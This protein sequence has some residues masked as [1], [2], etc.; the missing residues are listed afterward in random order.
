MT[1]SV[2]ARRHHYEFAHRT[3]PE[4]VR[5]GRFDLVEMAEHDVL[6]PA[7]LGAW[8]ALGDALPPQE[9]VDAQGL[10]VWAVDLAGG[11]ALLVRFP[12]VQRLPEALLAAVLP[13]ADG[14]PPRYLTLEFAGT[15]DGQVQTMIGEWDGEA[16]R[17]WGVGPEPDPNA[18]V[19]ALEQLLRG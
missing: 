11:R 13:G 16:H 14:A 12:P 1:S 18:F 9:R 10:S 5:S 19:V 2:T 6:E 7:L 17:D 15:E 3:L 8:E 4:L